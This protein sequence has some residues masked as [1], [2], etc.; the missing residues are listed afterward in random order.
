MKFR[1]KGIL[2]KFKMFREK[3]KQLNLLEL[4]Y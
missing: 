1:Y 4:Q 2:S 3:N